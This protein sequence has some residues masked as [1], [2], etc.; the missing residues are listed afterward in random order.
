MNNLENKNNTNKTS[1]GYKVG[2]L[3][4]IV[5]VGCSMA[6]LLALT[7]KFIAWLF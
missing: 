3:F 5:I 2:Y 1:I 7:A 6:I 4:G